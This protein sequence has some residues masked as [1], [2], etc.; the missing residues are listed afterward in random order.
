MSLRHMETCLEYL[1]DCLLCKF[2]ISF[3]QNRYVK[4]PCVV[5]WTCLYYTGGANL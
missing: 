4:L 1:L 3:L 2:K 5:L